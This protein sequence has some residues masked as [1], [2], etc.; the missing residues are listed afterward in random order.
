MSIQTCFQLN[1]PD[2]HLAKKPIIANI[3]TNHETTNIDLNL[4]YSCSDFLTKNQAIDSDSIENQVEIFIQSY[5]EAVN[6]LKVKE[7]NSQIFLN[8]MA[9]HK[10][11]FKSNSFFD[12]FKLAKYFCVRDLLLHLQKTC[13]KIQ[14]PN[15]IFSVLQKGQISKEEEEYFIRFLYCG[16]MRQKLS[17]KINECFE[18]NFFTSHFPINATFRILKSC[19]SIDLIPANKL[20][21]FIIQS[22]DENYRLLPFLDFYRLDDSQKETFCILFSDFV[23]K[24][25]E[26]SQDNENNIS[27]SSNYLLENKLKLSEMKMNNMK[28]KIKSLQT[29]NEQLKKKVDSNEEKDTLKKNLND[30]K[31]KL[32]NELK[33]EN[34][35]LK[36]KNKKIFC[37]LHDLSS[38]IDNLEKQIESLQIENIRLKKL[39]SEIQNCIDEKSSQSLSRFERK[40]YHDSCS[41]QNQ[42]FDRI[43]IINYENKKIIERGVYKNSKHGQ[44][45]RIKRDNKS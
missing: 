21:D 42:S 31:D 7:A 29:E 34:E 16:H 5:C 32:I 4:F 35:Q 40:K 19:K 20:Y 37:N 12:I 9:G 24:N 44:V 11:T 3:C 17:E 18:N 25:D 33:H 22:F 27:N 14:D 45:N 28:W 2:Q 10:T 38:S 6:K 15:Q 36:E 1:D 26:K 43:K 13:D 39:K 8:I 30:S 23:K 41:K